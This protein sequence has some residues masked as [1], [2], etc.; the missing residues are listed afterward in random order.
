MK[1]AR[2]CILMCVWG[3]FAIQCTV[4][5]TTSHSE[6]R[7]GGGSSFKSSGKRSSGN[8]SSNSSSSNSSSSSSSSSN[9]SDADWDDVVLALKFIGTPMLLPL[10]GSFIYAG[11]LG[12]QGKATAMNKDIPDA[13]VRLLNSLVMIMLGVIGCI[14]LGYTLFFMSHAVGLA[15]QFIYFVASLLCIS[16]KDKVMV[17]AGLKKPGKETIISSPT[18]ETRVRLIH[19]VDKHVEAFKVR[20]PNFSKVLF[21]D[22]VSALYHKYYTYRGKSEFAALTPFL[23][24]ELITEASK[25]RY[26]PITV[27]EIV[28]GGMQIKIFQDSQKPF[29]DLSDFLHETDWIEVQIDANYTATVGGKSTRHVVLER[30]LFQRQKGTLSPEPDK[31]RD[32]A[33]PACGAPAHVT[34]SGKCDYCGII[35]KAGTMQWMAAKRHIL[36]SNV[37]DTQELGTYAQEVGTDWPTVKQAG[38]PGMMAHFQKAHRIEHWDS[39]WEGFQEHIVTPFFLDIYEKWTLQ[40]WGAVRHLVSDRLFET[41]DFWIQAYQDEGFVNKLERISISRIDLARIDVDAFYETF[42]VRIF[43]SCLDYVE[44]QQGRLI[45]GS[46]RRPRKFSEYWT[47]IR[48]TGVEQ[49]DAQFDLKTCPNC[50][51]LAD[52]MGQAAECDYCNAKIS[53]GDFSWV[54]AIITQD[55]VYA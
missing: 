38:L 25:T 43:A 23:T 29:T 32:V 44:N 30:W 28:I 12:V 40:N 52:K 15:F 7:P 33:C 49:H 16:L 11:W 10:L 34:D 48:R 53:N 2:W 55:E 5:F 22:F 24:D 31:M 18:H 36:Q 13:T 47:F 20:D 50:G 19:G 1:R 41:N 54:L 51:A 8:S 46:K 3:F 27:T 6:A 35:L 45:G 37:F 39:Y 4:L 9:Y 14:G 42:T 17:N 21:L 26:T